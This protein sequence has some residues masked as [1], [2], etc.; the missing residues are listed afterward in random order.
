MA[1]SEHNTKKFLGQIYTPAHIV[2]KILDSVG[3]D[4]PSALGRPIL[5]PAC[6]DGRFLVEAVNRIAK[7]SDEKDLE[8]NLTHVHGWDIDPVAVAVC[9]ENLDRAVAHLGVKVKWNVQLADS[10]KFGLFTQ[11]RFDFVVGNP[12]YIRIQNLSSEVR[13]Y[14]QQNFW[15]C[16]RGSTD[17]YLAFC[18][19]AEK[20][21]SPSGVCGFITPNTYF[22]TKAGEAMRQ[23]FELA[24]TIRHITN[25]GSTEVFPGVSI[26][27]AVTVFGKDHQPGFLYER[28]KSPSDIESRQIPLNEI[29]GQKV[30]GLSAKPPE[31]PAK[32]GVRLGDTCEI[33]TGLATL[34]DKAYIFPTEPINQSYVW[35]YT[36]LRGRVKLE[37]ALLKPIIKVSTFNDGD[38][39]TEH[40]LFPYEK[41]GDGY[42]ILSEEALASYPLAYEY[43]LSVK[44]ELDKRDR[45]KPNPVAWYA[46]GRSQS[47]NTGFGRKIIFSPINKAPN[48]IL[49]EE[50]E[51]TFYSGYCIKSKWNPHWLLERLNSQKMA[52]HID[53]FGRDFQGGWKSYSKSVLMDYMLEH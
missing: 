53:T 38:P 35:A 3:F 48:F 37:R 4:G 14:I 22:H 6:G 42:R 34:C 27:T 2:H 20:L 10:L 36:K 5:D 8:E 41:V 13:K 25:Y 24:G 21:L 33:H 45:G 51:T 19:L 17:M 23:F 12:P 31:T 9:K 47:I 15:F 30:W 32:R 43:L 29:K 44:D 40:V 7:C 1:K 28:V 49:C 52:D 50:D 18:E 11:Q 39:I 16:K 46:F 26:F